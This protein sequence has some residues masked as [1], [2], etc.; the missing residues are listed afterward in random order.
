MLRRLRPGFGS[1]EVIGING[2]VRPFRMRSITFASKGIQR[3]V[4]GKK[5]ELNEL[6]FRYQLQ[7]GPQSD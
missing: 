2:F 4:F 3:R 7:D 6:S 5:I 1:L